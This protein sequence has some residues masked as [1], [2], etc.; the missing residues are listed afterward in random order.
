M[1]PPRHARP[2]ARQLIVPVVGLLLA[3]VLVSVAAS[4]WLGA[5][6]SRTEARAAQERLAAA[7]REAR[8]PLSQPILDT[9]ARLTGSDFVVWN[10][11]ERAAG[12]ATVPAEILGRTDVAAVAAAAGGTALVAGAPHRVGVVRLEGVRPE[13]VL[14]L[15]P[16]PGLARTLADALWPELAVAALMLAVLVPLGLRLAGRLAARIAA[17]ERH[18]GTIAAGEFGH[19]LGADDAASDDEI[20]RL[21]AGVDRMSRTL[22]GLRD[23]LIAGE[24]QRLLG[25]LAAGFA[26]ELRNAVTGAKL[27][28]GLHRRR[29]PAAAGPGAA[30]AGPDRPD[31]SLDVAA[32]QLDVLEEEVRGLLALGRPDESRPVRLA[33][34]DL[35]GEVRDLTAP[36]CDHAGVRLE[37]A[38][39]AAAVV[40][41]RE[42]LRAA[43]VNL[44]LNG[45]DAAGRDGTVRLSAAEHDG[46]VS[47]AVEDTGPGPPES[48]RDTIHEPFVTGKPEGIGLVLAVARAVAESHG[49]ALAWDRTGGLTRFTI[50]LPA[51]EAP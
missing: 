31:D 47:L 35:F 2:L 38:P 44:A 13:T 39:S 21:A 18:V 20:G 27:A 1:T 49:G 19:T 33:V 30:A 36:R 42:A 26:H 46:R 5:R 17:V 40:G 29:C 22:A 8:F 23:T 34:A 51:A 10:A 14:V 6:R 11:T 41:R 4:A 45:I 7:L 37:C 25:Q 32:R 16:V 9:L 28:I 3:C 24:R 12:L 43:L 15:T 50:S 48:I